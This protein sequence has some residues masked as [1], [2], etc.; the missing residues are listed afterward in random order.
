MNLFETVKASVSVPDAAKMYGL[1]PNH[2]SI[3]RDPDTGRCGEGSISLSQQGTRYSRM[4]CFW[5]RPSAGTMHGGRNRDT[6]A[7][8]TIEDAKTEKHTAG[9]PCGAYIESPCKF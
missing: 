5:M 3:C 9:S 8:T 2:H 4:S 6:A 7:M 1:R